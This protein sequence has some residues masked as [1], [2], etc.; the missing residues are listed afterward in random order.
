M[1]LPNTLTS[2]TPAGSDSPSLG[3]DIIRAFKLAMVDILGIPD[4]TA[5][6]QAAFN[7]D[8]GGLAQ[9][10]FYDPAVEPASG[11]LGRNGSTLKYR[12]ED[13]RT[14]TTIRPFAVAA[15]TSGTPAA[16]MGVGQ[17]FQAESADEVPSDAG[18]LDFVFSDVTAASEDTYASLF[19]RV[20]G[21]ALDEKYRFGSTAGDGFAAIFTHANTADRTVTLPDADITVA[22][23]ADLTTHTGASAAIHGLPA[24]VNVLGN[25]AAAAEFVQRATV[26]PGATAGANADVFINVTA[27]TFA[28][29]FSTTPF[30]APA[31]T[32]HASATNIV[33]F[34]AQ[35]ITTTGFNMLTFSFASGVDI[36]DARYIALGA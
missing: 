10:I 19:L 25:R 11:E 20:A 18:A 4:A 34:S 17:L 5:I 7:I 27:V 33:F 23:T 29:A 16:G 22:S 30:V 35:S 21:R 28:V 1:A 9:V 8:A 32:T 12:I 2:T 26:D 3:D 24:S 15:T 6:S 31:G 36:A 13:S 14:A